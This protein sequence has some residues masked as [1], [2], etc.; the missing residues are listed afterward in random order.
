LREEAT[1]DK[2][3]K[4]FYFW[5]VVNYGVNSKDRSISKTF[6]FTHTFYIVP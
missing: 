3:G 1:E 5:G 2:I 4:S 6:E